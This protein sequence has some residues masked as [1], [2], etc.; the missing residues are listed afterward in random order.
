MLL[1][2]LRQLIERVL[3]CCLL[4]RT[5][6]TLATF[7]RDPVKVQLPQQQVRVRRCFV[8]NSVSKVRR[9]DEYTIMNTQ[10]KYKW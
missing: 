4:F 7:A 6:E 1:F 3:Q 9:E 10:Y 5:D 8:C 2:K